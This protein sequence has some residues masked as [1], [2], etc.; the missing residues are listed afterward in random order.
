MVVLG[1]IFPNFDATTNEGK[2]YFADC[3]LVLIQLEPNFILIK[4]KGDIKFH[5][6]I[7]NS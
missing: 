6:Y 3:F 1:E 5:E 2:Q 4:Y 7:E